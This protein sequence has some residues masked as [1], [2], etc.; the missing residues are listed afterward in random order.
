MSSARGQEVITNPIEEIWMGKYEG[1]FC[2]GF[3]GAF[4][5]YTTRGLEDK[6]VELVQSTQKITP[7]I[8]KKLKNL[9]TQLNEKKLFTEESYLNLLNFFN[10]MK[11][12]QDKDLIRLDITSKSINQLTFKD[13]K[14]I[15]H[16]YADEFLYTADEFD[17]Y[18]VELQKIL[19]KEKFPLVI[20]VCLMPDNMDSRTNHDIGLSYNAEL[21]SYCLADINALS[22]SLPH[23]TKQGTIIK[24][25]ILQSI[26]SE[27]LSKLLKDRYFSKSNYIAACINIYSIKSQKE[28]KSVFKPLKIFQNNF[29]SN[30]RDLITRKATH[31]GETILHLAAYNDN[32][33]KIKKLSKYK[34]LLQQKNLHEE[35]LLF[36]ASK[37]SSLKV[38]KFLIKKNIFSLD[39]IN[40]EGITPTFFAA[41]NNNVKVLE[42]L[43]IHNANL[44]LVREIDRESPVQIAAYKGSLES[45]QILL[46]SEYKVN[47]NHQNYRGETAV[48]IAAFHNH[49]D[50][51]ELLRKY[52]ADLTIPRTDLDYEPIHVAAQQDSVESLEFLLKMGISPDK[53]TKSEYKTPLHIAAAQNK[54]KTIMSLIRNGADINSTALYLYTPLHS[55]II[56]GN[57]DTVRVLIKAGADILAEVADGNACSAVG[58]ALLEKE[59][60]KA[61]LLLL[62]VPFNDL[63]RSDKE[64]IIKNNQELLQYFDKIYA[65]I[66]GE[67]PNKIKELRHNILTF[68]FKNNKLSFNKFTPMLKLVGIFNHLEGESINCNPCPS[69]FN[70]KQIV[71]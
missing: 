24:E 55:A 17:L 34:K 57:I 61:V 38:M 10:L 22:V 68:L 4:T 43:A 29:L 60:D 53:S 3:T 45:L 12:F 71:I 1:G 9:N 16:V 5:E 40:I 56:D 23:D 33:T 7:N 41:Q 54:L 37:Y 20:E 2:A 63:T 26:K 69:S 64:L 15:N 30:T 67:I 13:D 28:F 27:N 39:E 19:K 11:F 47:I 58:L 59:W 18:F 25:T 49:V 66:C 51:L 42:L 31:N 70:S 46:H 32:L 62:N 48:S 50:I 65:S 6:F 21:N 35:S 14:P 44:N 36:F 8:I 52:G